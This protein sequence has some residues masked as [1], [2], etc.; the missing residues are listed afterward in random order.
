MLSRAS[1]QRCRT[2]HPLGA[3]TARFSGPR[4]RAEQTTPTGSTDVLVRETRQHVCRGSA[5][6]PFPAGL[7]PARGSMAAAL[8]NAPLRGVCPDAS[9]PQC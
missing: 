8:Q 1:R 4:S 2:R 7:R 3:R 5:A 6:R 9:G